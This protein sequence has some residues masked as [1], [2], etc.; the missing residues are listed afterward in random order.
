VAPGLTLTANEPLR[1]TVTG[2]ATLAFTDGPSL[3]KNNNNTPAGYVDQAMQ[4]VDGKG[5]GTGTTYNF[6]IPSGSSSITLA[7]FNVGTVAGNIRIAIA[8]DGLAQT[9]GLVIVPPATPVIDSGSV[10]FTNVTSTGFHLELVGTSGTRSVT[11]AMVTLNPKPGNQIV[12]QSTFT[13]DVSKVMDG[14]FSSSASLAYGGRFSL[15]IPFELGG[16]LNAIDSATVTISATSG[17]PS[18]PVTGKK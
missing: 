1:E 18:Q 13:L 15:T 9:G 11:T 7:G 12:G 10:Q 3:N 17:N 16:D 6:T 5:N 4:F 14:W 8:A 2:T